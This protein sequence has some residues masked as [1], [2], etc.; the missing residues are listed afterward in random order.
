MKLTNCVHQ[1]HPSASTISPSMSNAILDDEQSMSRLGSLRNPYASKW[2]LGL[3]PQILA[4]CRILYAEGKHILYNNKIVRVSY[5]S[6]KAIKPRAH[7]TGEEWIK[8]AMEE[9]SALKQTERWAIEIS[10]DCEQR[11]H[12]Y[13]TEDPSGIILWVHTVYSWTSPLCCPLMTWSTWSL[14]LLV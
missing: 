7:V 13:R 4:T 12:H 1:T 8:E 3:H 11:I 10:S 5:F 6:D 2:T 9:Y 14:R